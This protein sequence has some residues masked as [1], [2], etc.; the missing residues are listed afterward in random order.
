MTR[1]Y[2]HRQVGRA[3]SWDVSKR[4]VT[5]EEMDDASLD[6]A[7]HREALEG[8][9]RL[10]FVSCSARLLWRTIRPMG[11]VRVLD[12]ACGGGDVTV[13]LWR[14]ARQRGVT[15]RIE[16]V[17]RSPV[18]VEK[19]QERARRAGAEIRFFEIDALRDTLSTGGDYDVVMS[20]LFMHHLTEAQA[21]VLLR[22]MAAAAGRMVLINDLIRCRAGLLL[23]WS[24]SR[25]LTR[26]PVV[27]VDAVRSVRAA[28]TEAEAVALAE[29]AGLT[30]ATVSWRWPWRFLLQWRRC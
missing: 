20:S 8:L 19:A 21:Q 16:G 4:L 13:G 26:G 23:A 17:D 25:L 18:A 22:R 15:L 11:D 9:S 14:L 7:L 1:A 3:P 27:A 6:A 12:V 24:A 5:A 29:A 10:N 30:G 2:D 28:F